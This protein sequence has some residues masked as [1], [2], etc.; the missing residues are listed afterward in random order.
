MSVA[1][2][3]RHQ[4]EALGEYVTRANIDWFAVFPDKLAE[5][6]GTAAAG[7]RASN[8]IVYRTRSGDDRDHHVIPLSDLAELLTED[9]LTHSE[10]N[11]TVRWNVTLKDHVVR[12][13][14][15]SLGVDVNQYFRAPLAIELGDLGGDMLRPI[16]IDPPGRVAATTYRILRDTAEA[17]RLKADHDYRCQICDATIELPDGTRY[18]E[19]HHIRPLGRPHNGPDLRENMIVLC[20][21]HHA[22]CD[23]G[24][25]RLSLPALRRIDNHVVGPAFIAYHNDRLYRSVA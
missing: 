4:L 15:T 2:N 8:L 11:G 6:N 21:N 16:D 17:R 24:V 18:A 5:L 3:N 9:T 7:R 12:V 14:H 13:S 25:I 20:P 23:Y 19:A 10:V 22:M 1:H